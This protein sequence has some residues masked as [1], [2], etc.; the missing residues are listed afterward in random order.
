[1]NSSRLL[2]ASAAVATLAFVAYILVTHVLDLGEDAGMVAT[3]PVSTEQKQ[4]TRDILSYVPADTIYFFGGLESAPLKNMLDFYRPEWSL[5]QT[6]DLRQGL[7]ADPN[8]SVAGKMLIGMFAE[9]IDTLK[10]VKTA[11]STFGIGS[12]LDAAFYSVGTTP[13]MRIKLADT[14]AFN[15]F[16]KRAETS[17]QIFPTQESHGP[18]TLS[19]YSFNPPKNT[20]EN[21]LENEPANGQKN[22]QEKSA[23]V[24]LA[25]SV[26]NNYALIT[27]LTPLETPATRD[28]ILG[29]KKPTQALINTNILQDLK[30]KYNFHPAYL[31]YISYEEIM[32]GL[33]DPNGNE[34]G[35]MMGSLLKAANEQRTKIAA[36]KV[37]EAQNSPNADSEATPEA[38]PVTQVEATPENPLESIQT[39]AC[40]SEL[41]AI[42]TLWPRTVF[43]Y[44]ELSLETKPKKISMLMLTENTDAAFMQQLQ[45]LRG[46]VPAHLRTVE[47]KP[48]LGFGLGFSV[49][50]LTPVVSQLITGFTQKEYECQ[51]L[52]DMK[53]NL[54][55]SNPLLAMGM[56]TGMA[57][58]I[59]GISAT[60]LDIDGTMNIDPETSQPSPD[61]RSIDA[62][63]TLSAKDPQR[64]LALA[65][66]FMQGMPPIQLPADG[67]AIDLPVPLPIP[68][69]LGSVK[70]ALKGNHIVAYIGSKA[71]QL[72][73]K[74]SGDPLAAT[75]VLAFNM[76]F[77]KYM[78]L[79]SN[80]TLAA[81]AIEGAT[82]EESIPAET[83]AALKEMTK[84]DMQIV[85]SFDITPQG[86]SVDATMTMN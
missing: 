83:Q 10:D 15:A 21:S 57:A 63:I 52:A 66:N 1:M 82:P 71:E 24:K 30:S 12:E 72:A 73:Q 85:E 29:A 76:D 60:I 67:S 46:F 7:A 77:G 69:N 55:T 58:G 39:A 47:S 48:V 22:E 33:T 19:T 27:L 62:M 6:T 84:M 42:T 28:V 17:V 79:I 4:P 23:D 80:I 41:M 51:P 64:L 56:M 36:Q 31:G 50:Q 70:L 34:F 53:Q 65:A 74:M 75:G 20:L 44:T 2:Q 61:I 8:M 78:G 13:V 40:R 26:N 81:G 38:T 32:K 43:G 37:A 45:Q 14:D 9:Y 5:A 3:S 11:S 68:P 86:L 54:Q 25:I 59:E 18:M 35:A 49:D 16:I